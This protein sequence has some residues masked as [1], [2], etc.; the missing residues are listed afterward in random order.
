MTGRIVIFMLLLSLALVSCGD[1]I[2]DTGPPPCPVPE[3]RVEDDDCT[4]ASVVAAVCSKYCFD[5]LRNQLN[6]LARQAFISTDL[7]DALR[8]WIDDVE[9]PFENALVRHHDQFCASQS[10]VSEDIFQVADLD[11]LPSPVFFDTPVARGYWWYNVRVIIRD[12]GTVGCSANSVRNTTN[13]IDLASGT[14]SPLITGP[15][16]YHVCD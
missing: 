16:G 6:G 1:G 15:G 3:T 12:D 10:D 8:A 7:T 14:P 9:R 5:S 4:T 11:N 2:S 13:S